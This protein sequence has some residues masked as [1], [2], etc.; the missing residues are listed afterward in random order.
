MLI[1]SAASGGEEKREEGRR[2]EEGWEEKEGRKRRERKRG[3]ECIVNVQVNKSLSRGRVTN[4]YRLQL[5]P[6]CVCV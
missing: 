1:P 4:H 5:W 2:D 3:G 6:L